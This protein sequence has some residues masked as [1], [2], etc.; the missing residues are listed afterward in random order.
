MP[1]DYLDDIAISDVAFHAR[2]DT[3]EGLFGDAAEALIN[4]MVEDLDSVKERVRRRITVQAESV[5]MLLFQFLQ[6]LIFYKD[7]EQ[8]LL[9]PADMEIGRRDEE[10]VL[11]CVARGEKMDPDRH[12]LHVDVKAVT[13]HRFSVKSTPG[14]WEATVVL[15]T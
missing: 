1:Y 7:A 3:L 9:L 6:E 11:S 13:F 15:D 5:E 4:T 12:D 14:G 10:Y 8:E 2:S